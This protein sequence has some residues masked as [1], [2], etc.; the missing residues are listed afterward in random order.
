MIFCASASLIPGRA[1][2]AFFVAV[3][4]STIVVFGLAADGVVAFGVG[5]LAT[6]FPVVCAN[7]EPTRRI[8]KEMIV[9]EFLVRFIV[10]LPLA[11][12]RDIL[13]PCPIPT[14]S[15]KPTRYYVLS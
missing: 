6:W 2:N 7:D 15:V 13:E 4:R 10:N 8:S 11:I 9:M 12:V 5:P 3:L 1:I 14:F